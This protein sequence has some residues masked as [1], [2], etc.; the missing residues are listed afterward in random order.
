MDITFDKRD[1]FNRKIIAE[2]TISLLGGSV[3]VSC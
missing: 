2:N 1:E 3:D